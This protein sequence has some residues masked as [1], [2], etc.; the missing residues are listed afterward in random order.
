MLFLNFFNRVLRLL[1]F[2]FCLCIIIVLCFYVV[3]LSLV[4]KLINFAQ[5]YQVD[6]QLGYDYILQ[7]N[8]FKIFITNDTVAAR[9]KYSLGRT[10]F[11]SQQ[12]ILLPLWSSLVR[13]VLACQITSSFNEK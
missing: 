11:D 9:L 1:C 7:C 2:C 13:G 6:S 8:I 12:G 3:C 4:Y 10:Q 5:H